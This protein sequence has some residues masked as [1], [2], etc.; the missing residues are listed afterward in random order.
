V[1][2]IIEGKTERKAPR[3]RPRDKYKGQ[4]NNKVYCSKYTEESQLALAGIGWKVTV[5]QS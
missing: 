1:K 5:N 2:S 3:G 4:I